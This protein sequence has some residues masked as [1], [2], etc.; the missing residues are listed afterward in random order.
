MKTVLVEYQIEE[1]AKEEYMRWIRE[2]A[3]ADG[4]AVFEGDGQPGLFLES[5]TMAAEK[6]LPFREERTGTA[7]SPWR[8]LDAYLAKDRP[9]V[10]VW[11]FSPIK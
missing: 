8:K 4:F 7:P 2:R 10:H 6:C 1:N 5:W 3:E 11:I 9:R